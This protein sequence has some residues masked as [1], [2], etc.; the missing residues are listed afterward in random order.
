MRKTF[1]VMIGGKFAPLTI[2]K[3]TEEGGDLDT[4]TRTFS[5]AITDTAM[6][7]LGKHRPEK[8]KWIT[9]N[10]LEM[11]DE[12]RELKNKKRSTRTK[13]IQRNKQ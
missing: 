8:E 2:L 13:P 11:C 6:E 1:K 5:R 4:L 12:R 10:I 7:T 3:D 9:A